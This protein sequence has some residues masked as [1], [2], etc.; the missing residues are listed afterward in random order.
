MKYLETRGEARHLEQV[1]PA[2]T[3]ADEAIFDSVAAL[4]HR[5]ACE[6]PIVEAAP[7]YED[8]DVLLLESLQRDTNA[9]QP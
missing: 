8:D 1:K 5:A 4:F 3:V 9:D 2:G 7:V 6:R